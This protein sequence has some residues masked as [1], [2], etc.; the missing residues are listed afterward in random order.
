M[1]YSHVPC[2]IDHAI[3][4]CAESLAENLVYE[5]DHKNV[6][7]IDD[8]REVVFD[9][10]IED[11]L[12]LKLSLDHRLKAVEYFGDD[13]GLT[14]EDADLSNLRGTIEGLACAV[15]HYQACSL[16]DSAIDELEQLMDDE[17]LEFE[18]SVRSNSFGWARHYGERYI[19]D[20]CTVYE[21]R[22]VEGIH[23]DIYVFRMLDT[24]ICFQKSIDP[25]ELTGEEITFNA[26]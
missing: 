26:I 5:I 18:N 22:N 20:D 11:T 8:C 16:V 24:E 7:S 6:D 19:G 17:D 21:Y 15:I 9:S 12:A 4:N 14:L 10:H 25:A 1:D 3:Q 13:H 2:E 23:V